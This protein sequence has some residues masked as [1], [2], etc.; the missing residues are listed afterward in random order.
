MRIL[1]EV[2]VGIGKGVVGGLIDCGLVGGE[3][4]ELR[5]AELSLCSFSMYNWCCCSISCLIDWR[6]VSFDQLFLW[7]GV[8]GSSSI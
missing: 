6:K 1:L 5:E 2:V 8:S 3:R 7:E 4:E